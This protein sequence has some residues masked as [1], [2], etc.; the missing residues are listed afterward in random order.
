MINLCTRR[1]ALAAFTV[2][3]QLAA[4]PWASSAQEDGDKED[5]AVPLTVTGTVLD[6]A[7]QPLPGATIE[8]GVDTQ[9]FSARQRVVTDR[10]GHYSIRRGRIEERARLAASAPGFSAQLM[11]W[12]AEPGAGPIDFQLQRIPKDAAFVA[13]TVVDDYG[14][15][16]AGV[17]VE[18]F[19]P[20]VGVHSSFSW[21]TGRDYFPGPDR[22]ATTDADGA[23]RIEDLAQP[24]FNDTG[25]VHLSL[26]SEH[27]HVNDANYPLGAG[28]TI[29]MHGSGRA[30]VLRGRLV[31]AKDGLP[32]ASPKAVRIVQRHRTDVFDDVDD[33]GCLELPGPVTLGNTYSVN[34]YVA[35]YAA[36]EARLTAVNADSG[37]IADILLTPAP[38]LH[39]RLVDADNGAPI[40]GAELLY[41]LVGKVSYFEWSSFAKYTDGLHGLKF[42]QHA[43]TDAEG[44]FWFCEP[45]EG[46]HG[47]IIGR[48][49]GY[50]EIVLS[51]A[52]R[53][54]A[55]ETG[56]LVVRLPR[57]AV[58]MGLVVKDGKPVTEERVSVTG[59]KRGGLEQ[60]RVGVKTDAEG[61]Y[62]YGGLAAGEYVLHANGFAQPV[63]LGHAEQADVDLG[64]DAGTW[65]V[66]GF[67]PA[68]VSIAFSPMFDWQCRQLDAEADKEGRYQVQGLKPGRYRVRIDY[69]GRGFSRDHE[70]E[71]EVTRD[72]Q[73]VD[74][75][76]RRPPQ[77]KATT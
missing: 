31:D 34:V 42:V 12:D 18:A 52:E 15:P 30:G 41:G 74:L 17:V 54:I 38:T 50:A 48:P 63:T 72:G 61:R 65:S 5:A 57:E 43:T 8:W 1:I 16:V 24:L 56:T 45:P 44:R 60:W 2:L 53:T 20:V 40:A 10:E 35:G 25:E 33:Q 7:G 36:A 46:E 70:V 6:D 62:R 28:V 67:A 9:R 14:E 39:G 11:G 77:P 58:V 19:T 69:V 3:T 37:G 66:H 27:R 73:Q 55:P 32:I 51:P 68:G 47:T 59:A 21:P 23:F 75:E 64:H 13:G 71:V 22:K 76:W 29:R 4:S 26:R 49:A